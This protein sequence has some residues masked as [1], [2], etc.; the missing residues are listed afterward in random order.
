M[1]YGSR[2]KLHLDSP[3]ATSLIRSYGSGQVRIGEVTHATSVIVT[4]STVLAPW[5]P[6]NVD[7]LREADLEP[8]LALAPEV[9]LLGTGPRQQFPSPALL[10]LLHSLRIGVE[11]MD[12]AAACRTYN[13]L[14]TEGRS[15]A[16]A[17][18]L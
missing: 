12:T 1:Q 2:M 5:R 8:L 18:M 16:A 14:A 7:D 10:Q 15:V 17:L 9:V 6:Q 4:A 3:A 13:V 11:I